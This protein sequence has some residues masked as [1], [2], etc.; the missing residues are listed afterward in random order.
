MAARKL[1]ALATACDGLEHPAGSLRCVACVDAMGSACDGPGACKGSENGIDAT[2]HPVRDAWMRLV[3][4][5][6]GL[7]EARPWPAPEVTKKKQHQRTNRCHAWPSE[8]APPSH[9]LCL[10]CAPRA[11]HAT[12]LRG[13][14][15]WRCKSRSM[16]G[17]SKPLGAGLGMPRSRYAANALHD[18]PKLCMF[19]CG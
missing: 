5:V 11:W 7:V 9:R 18:G 19:G 6:N 16:V 12:R 10:A 14:P 3:G 2:H 4:F 17:N 8:I 13:A 1:Q 15:C